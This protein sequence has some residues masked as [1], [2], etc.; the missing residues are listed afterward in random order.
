MGFKFTYRQSSENWIL[1]SIRFNKWG[2]RQTCLLE[3]LQKDSTTGVAPGKSLSEVRCRQGGFF[4][5]GAAGIKIRAS[6]VTLQ[7]TGNRSRT[8]AY[9]TERA[10]STRIRESCIRSLDER[11]FA[12]KVSLFPRASRLDVKNPTNRPTRD[13]PGEIAWRHHDRSCLVR[14]LGIR[15]QG[16][17]VTLLPAGP[18]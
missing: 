9:H 8:R 17:G 5:L 10:L 14:K 4:S 16:L 7:V 18:D 6:A 1:E 15:G 12:S 2:A 11:A 13:A 3:P